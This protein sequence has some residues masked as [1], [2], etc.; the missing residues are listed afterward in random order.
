MNTKLFSVK[1]IA[2]FVVMLAFVGSLSSQTFTTVS[3]NKTPKATVSVSSTST[4]PTKETPQTTT[5]TSDIIVSAGAKTQT[6]NH[7]AEIAADAAYYSVSD[8]PIYADGN[9]EIPLLVMQ[10]AKYPAEAIKQKAH[11]IVLV[12][13]IV[14][15]DG[16]ISNPTV[17]S[18]VHPLLDKEALRVV[19]TLKKFTPAK[20]NGEVVR[21]YFQVPVP[22]MLP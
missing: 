17:I 9:A 12:Q 4:S 5:Q 6:I 15:K 20:N 7:T 11:G 1:A 19:G 3:K 2:L 10:K 14:E 13:F 16:S 21:C 8:L 18:N 22:F